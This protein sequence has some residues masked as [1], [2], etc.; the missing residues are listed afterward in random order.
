M[1]TLAT[2]LSS[3][4]D[5]DINPDKLKDLMNTV[6]AEVDESLKVREKHYCQFGD[7]N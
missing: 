3:I 5:S 2:H 7:T 6:Y 1:Q 4:A